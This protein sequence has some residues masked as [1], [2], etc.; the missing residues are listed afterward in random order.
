MRAGLLNEIITI[1]RA[2][3][4]KN[5]YGEEEE[6]WSTVYTTRARIEQT[7]SD[8]VIEND[9]VIMTYTKTFQMRYYVPIQPFDVIEW[10]SQKYRVMSID[11]DRANVHIIVI[12][13]LINE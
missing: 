13:E 5:V 12:G 11:K 1:K 2:T 3:I 4:T 10:N 8:K 6:T 7:K 9:E